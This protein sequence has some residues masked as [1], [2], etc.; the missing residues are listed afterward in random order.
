MLDI[1]TV[2]LKN[3]LF[4]S[5]NTST[6]DVSAIERYNTLLGRNF[7]AQ[8]ALEIAS[9]NTNSAT[10]SLM[11]SANGA[12]ISIEQMTEAQKASTVSAKA[13]SVAL[14]ALSIAG[15]AI[16]FALIS[17]GIQIASKAIDEYVHR[18][19]YAIERMEEAEQTISDS[20]TKLR[21]LSSTI[22]ENRDRFLELSEGVDKF[23]RN[24]K[25]SEEDYAEYL[26]ISNQLAEISPT[27][28]SGYDDQGNALIRLG[29]NA[30]DTNAKLNDILETEKALAEQTLIDN[31]DSVA[32]GVYYQVEQASN[33][34]ARLQEELDSLSDIEGLKLPENLFQDV[35]ENTKSFDYGS[36]RDTFGTEE[37]DKLRQLI[38]DSGARV[39]EDETFDTMSIFAKDIGLVE[40]AIKNF[41]SQMG[42]VA[43]NES[44]AYVNGLK[45]DIDEQEK[46]IKETYSKMNS[47][48][49]AWVKSTYEYDYLDDSQK[50]LIKS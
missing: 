3:T 17:K 27:L 18:V 7:S 34:I 43:N 8:K 41:Y 26:S 13:Q 29:E 21:N 15:N 30:E 23:S 36:L 11:E 42:Y 45:K 28:V 31:L 22:E 47:N 39:F 4:Q 44:S 6:I 19:E 10:I 25:L 32:E 2:G 33:E 38:L 12:T 40:N 46:T 14:K 49:S 24:V 16:A 9:K 20:Q 35:D 37:I 5:L 48:L 1:Q 50:N